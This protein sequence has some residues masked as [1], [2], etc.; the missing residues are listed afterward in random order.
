[1]HLSRTGCVTYG[2]ARML[3]WRFIL[4]V[5]FAAI[6]IGLCWLDAHSAQ[7]GA[8]LAPLLLLIA[9]VASDELLRMARGVAPGTLTSM[10]CVGSLV[11]VGASFIPH[12]WPAELGS[13]AAALGA[14]GWTALAI[15][16]ATLLIFAVEMIRY[17]APGVHTQRLALSALAFL[18]VGVL[19]SFLAQLRFVGPGRNMGLVALISMT[20]VVKFADIGAYTV[21]RLIG[22]HKMAP[23]LS[24]GKTLE[25][26]AGAMVFACFGAWLSLNVL[27]GPIAGEALA[28]VDAWRWIAYGL[29]VGIA[30]LAGDLAESL[31]K[32][33]LG[34]KDSSDWMPGFGG[35][36]DLVD[37]ILF[38]APV[39]YACW[40]FGLCRM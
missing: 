3:R 33:D 39:A 24:P 26:A 28:A 11:I 35:V 5:T 21:G 8:W 31:I 23:T 6:I 4:G 14:W 19:T 10:V 13:P 1:M 12:F 36:L 32:R 27:A 40:Q 25:G 2:K 37:S 7:P 16:A 29:V 38:A 30:G 15:G 20:V 18:Y 17:T 22:R 9:V 34:R